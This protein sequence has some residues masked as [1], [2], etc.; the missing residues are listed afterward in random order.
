[1]NSDLAVMVV[2]QSWL[3]YLNIVLAPQSAMQGRKPYWPLTSLTEGVQQTGF[4]V[5]A[6]VK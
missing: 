1:M 4:E 5:M 2:Q 3:Q 6:K